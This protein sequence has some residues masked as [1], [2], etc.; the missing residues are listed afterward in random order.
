MRTH[1]VILCF[2]SALFCFGMI[3]SDVSA[4]P[5]P[6]ALPEKALGNTEPEKSGEP[7]EKS[8]EP[9]FEPEEWEPEEEEEPEPEPEPLTLLN[10]FSAGWDKPFRN[11]SRFGRAP[12]LHLFTTK[13]PFLDREVRG[14]FNFLGNAEFGLANIYEVDF[15]FE[16]PFNRRYMIDV[17]P[18]YSWI[19]GR[20]GSRDVDALG[21]SLINFFQLVDTY[22]TTF[23]FQ[24][25]VTPPT[26]GL[27]IEVEEEESEELQGQSE[28]TE[29]NFVLAGFQ[30]V[31]HTLGWYRTGISGHLEYITLV[32]PNEPAESDHIVT[33]GVSIAKTLTDPDSPM[34]RDFTVFVENFGAVLLDG[35]E[36][37]QTNITLTPG[38]RW[39]FGQV[40]SPWWF[41]TG[42]EV[43]VS[44][45]REFDYTVRFSI[46]H[47][48][49]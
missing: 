8:E 47:W 27:G 19:Q 21:L 1:T 30:D 26:E 39:N 31:T 48:F 18:R 42:V 25:G 40:E 6:K 22:D 43:P 28:P 3:A 10:F 33:Y 15:E 45:P 35:E 7:E 9:E 44:S 32:G 29:L 14:N 16:I 46:I 38:F 41:M 20:R 23:N 49:D 11:R 13:Q 5:Y 37:G 36:S 2:V 17:E 12:R 4:Q 34:F 24:F